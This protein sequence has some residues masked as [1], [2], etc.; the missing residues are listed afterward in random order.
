MTWLKRLNAFNRGLMAPA[1]D[2]GAG[3]GGGDDAASVLFPGD[4][5][6]AG[7]KDTQPGGAG[8][9]TQAGGKGDQNKAEG[10]KEYE[11]DPAKSDEEN[12][13]A[14]AEHD[15]TK[16]AD[17]AGKGDA[18]KVP[19]DGKYALT[20]PEGVELD[21]EMMDALGPEFKDLGLT[22]AQAQK[23]ADKFISIQQGRG[24]KQTEAWG[25]TVQ[26]WADTAKSDTEIGGTRWDDTVKT[27]VGFMG[28]FTS[29]AGKEFLNASG[30][31]NHP[32]MIRMARNAGKALAE[33]R[34]ESD[35]LKKQLFGEDNPATGGAGGASKPVDAA[36]TLFPTDAP[37]G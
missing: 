31:G 17:D 33:A 10:W 37:K 6:G 11:N 35:N 36:Y 19:E 22:N 21:G 15:K 27:A 34:A 7:G 12:A 25:Q 8:D 32:E 2:G 30:A 23:L 16:P 13:A 14:K 4:A 24:A 29:D 9:D 20:M 1:D 3:G 26:G 5:A 28:E 18:D